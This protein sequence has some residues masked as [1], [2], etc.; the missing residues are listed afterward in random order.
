ML[1]PQTR[2][3]IFSYVVSAWLVGIIANLLI[4]GSYF[5]I[6]LRDLG[7]A[8]GAYALGQLAALHESHQVRSRTARPVSSRRQAA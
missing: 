7:L 8:I 4:L 3:R 2:P 1:H 6:A 5:D